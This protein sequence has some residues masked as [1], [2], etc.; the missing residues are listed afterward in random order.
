MSHGAWVD[1]RNCDRRVLRDMLGSFMTGVT[2]VAARNDEGRPS[3][4]T[5][6]SFT[7]VSLDPPLILVCLAKS[8]TS[9][10]VFSRAE[11]FSVNILGGWQRD[12]SAAFASRS[13]AK[14]A[15]L[16]T[17]TQGSP[18]TVD[19]S[20]ATIA[21]T[22]HQVVD[23]GDHIIL[24]GGVTAFTSKAGE[25]LGFF[26]GAYFDFGP[27]AS[28]DQVLWPIAASRGAAAPENAAG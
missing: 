11:R 26:R 14:D 25:P 13:P 18:P 27:A 5:A 2:V 24:I 16:E 8:S 28:G 21:C 1:A 20:L 12:L 17:L 23:A 3:A 7:S 22:Q 15:A 9:L 6:N 4:L 10:G 19:G